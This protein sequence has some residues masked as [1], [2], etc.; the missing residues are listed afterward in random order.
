M[1]ETTNQLKEKLRIMTGDRSFTLNNQD[2]S[3]I[4]LTKISSVASIHKTH[5]KI[6]TVEHNQRAEGYNFQAQSIYLEQNQSDNSY[7]TAANNYQ[8][9]N[10]S[11]VYEQSTVNLDHCFLIFIRQG[12]QCPFKSTA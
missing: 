1:T 3:T 11:L 8:T 12:K 2:R 5:D 7:S 6:S 9:N 10:D 4:K